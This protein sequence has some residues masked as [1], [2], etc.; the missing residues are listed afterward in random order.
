MDNL[1][2]R[3]LAIAGLIL[4]AW[5]FVA[6]VVVGGITAPAWVLPTAVMCVALAVVI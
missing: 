6:V 1:L 2:R 5:V 4:A 3:L